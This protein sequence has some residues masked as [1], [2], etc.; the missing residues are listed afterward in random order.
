MLVWVFGTSI[1][2]GVTN[3]PG[4][5]WPDRFAQM[6]GVTVRN[7]AVGGSAIDGTG[8]LL[9]EQVAAAGRSGEAPAFALIDAGTN[10]LVTHDLSALQRSKWAAIAADVALRDLGVPRRFWLTISPRGRGSAH[11]DGWL[12]NLTARAAAWNAWLRAMAGPFDVIDM[13]G[14]LHEDAE[15]LVQDPWL[16]PDGLHPSDDAALLMA[17]RVESAVRAAG[18]VAG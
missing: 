4:K 9:S 15:G 3:S 17:A 13:A 18:V 10:D 11:P 16:L 2:R 12:P 14:V 8:G 6:A 5:A 7:Y 1:P